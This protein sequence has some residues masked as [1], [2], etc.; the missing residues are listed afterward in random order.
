MALI[1]GRASDVD[2]EGF[3]VRVRLVL[4]K[5]GGPGVEISDGSEN[6]TCGS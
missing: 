5:D 6:L 4:D 2:S 1:V 3:G